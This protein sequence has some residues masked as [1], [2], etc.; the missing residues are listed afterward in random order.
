MAS[1]KK[2]FY[3]RKRW[4][5]AA[6][7]AIG[8]LLLF[9][10]SS[11]D[12]KPLVE[13]AGRRA[14]VA[15]H[16]DSARLG[17]HR[18]RIRNLAVGQVGKPEPFARVEF[19]ELAWHWWDLSR[20]RV[21]SV[22]LQ[23]PQLSLQRLQ[24]FQQSMA[25]KGAANDQVVTTKKSGG[26]WFSLLIKSVI[27]R[28]GSLML[29]NLGPGMPAVPIDVA[30]IDP[31]V[32]NNLKI[33]GGGDD[34][35]SQEDQTI[36]VQNLVIHSPYDPLTDVM[37]F[38]EISLTFSWAGIQHQE[39]KKLLIKKPTVYIGHDLFYF[40]DQLQAAPKA[41]NSQ[42][43]APV[44]ANEQVPPP[45]KIG[46]FHLWGGRLVVYSF[47]K[48]GFPLPMIFMAETDNMVLDNFAS[49]PFNKLGF[50]IPPTDLEYQQIGLKLRQLQGELFVG[51]PLSD[52]KAQNLTPNLSIE[53]VEWKGI[54]ATG[55]KTFVTFSRDGIITKLWAKTKE[56]M[57]PE[58]YDL[59][60]GVY[61]DL[62]DFSWAGWG[63]VDKIV[64]DHLTQMLSP[65]NFLMGGKATGH[66]SVRGKLSEVTGMGAVLKLN[67]TGKI[68]IVS[69]DEMMNK[70]PGDWW[71][72]KREAVR[73]LLEAF[74][75]YD[76]TLGETEFTYAPPESF[77]KL[78]LDGKQ[79][80]R[81]FDLR[82]HDLREKPGLGF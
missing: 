38:E 58:D 70:L 34:A 21:E 15:V 30:T 43:A 53:E 68:Q 39:L 49:L 28:D 5:L 56:H 20:G 60:A 4:W 24:E 36:S 1:G 18:V 33:G 62:N 16:V 46:H 71:Q 22:N 31:I 42:P 73:A 35:G 54:K 55:I 81:N 11:Q 66:F 72:P 19:I 64:L 41:A 65:E 76:Y 9:L 3:R 77:L 63:D 82:W 13:W 51:L 6:M 40:A 32:V 14:G 75:D 45:W 47:G 27:V 7:V 10:L 74:R 8:A 61:V 69:V 2:P 26:S 29:D 57:R 12:L 48:P 78:S 44:A 59:S 23:G 79:G 25:K 37:K 67:D 80:K 50:D 17:W 52:P